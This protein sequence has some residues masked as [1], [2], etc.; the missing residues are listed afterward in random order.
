MDDNSNFA[1]L[2]LDNRRE[3]NGFWYWREKPIGERGAVRNI[4]EAAGVQVTN[5]VSADQDP[6]DCEAMLD[7]KLSGVEVTELIHRRTLERSIKA[8]RQRSRGEEPQRSEAYF[9]WDRDDLLAVLQALLNVKNLAKLKKSYERYVLII[10]T[11]EFFL[12]RD[13]VRRFLD[14][15]SFRTSV[16]TD[17]FLGLSY[18]PS[19]KGFPTF[20]LELAQ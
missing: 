6:P 19:S 7:G 20:R 9:V 11:D 3:W 10:H 14:G 5:L 16:I 12:D 13:K 4:L 1:Q 15:A 18:D 2:I 17:A 8:V